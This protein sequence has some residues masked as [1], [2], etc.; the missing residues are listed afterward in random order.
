MRI[1]IASTYGSMTEMRSVKKFLEDDDHVVTARWIDGG[2]EGPGGRSMEAAAHM[3]IDDIQRAD[4]L[5]YMARP[6]GSASV[7]GG[8]HWEFGYAYALGKRCV[9][10]GQR[11]IVFCHL[12][13]LEVYSN[14]TEAREALR[15]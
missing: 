4:A 3:D 8:R 15:R 12:R 9:V 11:E 6:V 14:L 2:E 1:Y 5:F 10:V 13:G 7:G